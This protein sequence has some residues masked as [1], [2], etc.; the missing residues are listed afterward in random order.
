MLYPIGVFDSGLGGISVLRALMRKL[1][2]ESFIYFADSENAPYGCKSDAEIRE[3]TLIG[4]KALLALG[5][6]AIVLACNTATSV[7][8]EHLRS[9]LRVP[10]VGIEPAVKPAA[11]AYPNGRILVLATPV[12]LSHGKYRE[13]LS[14]IDHKGIV[15]VEAPRLVELV[16]GGRIDSSDATEYLE[17]IL[18]QYR[19]IRFDACVL[20]CTHFPFMKNSIISAL[21]YQ[22]D[23]FDGSDGAANRMKSLLQNNEILAYKN[24][25]RYIGFYNKY[26]SNIDRMLLYNKYNPI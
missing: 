14:R 21:G 12:T 6:K 13:L 20:G 7:A 1:P 9:I 15:S 5:C 8:V 18:S 16:E 3:L 11:L 22:P 26:S 10:I 24:T 17:H 25:C 2:N 23:F 4:S 19:G